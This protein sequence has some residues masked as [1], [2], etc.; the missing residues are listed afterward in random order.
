VRGVTVSLENPEAGIAPITRAATRVNDT[1]WR[2]DGIVIPTAGAWTVAV[3][4]LVSD[5][6]QVRLESRVAIGG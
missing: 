2:V 4:V 6:S 5:F 3:D 1:L